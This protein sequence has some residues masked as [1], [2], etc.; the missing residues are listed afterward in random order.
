MVQKILTNTGTPFAVA[1]S[2]D[3]T[4]GSWLPHHLFDGEFG[5]MSPTNTLWLRISGTVHQ[6]S[7]SGS[8]GI[9]RTDLSAV[10]PLSYNS[11][12]GVFTTSMGTG[13]LIGRGTAA[14]GVMEEITIGSGLTLSGTTLT[15]AG[16]GTPAG[17]TTEIQYNNAG[18]FGASD[19]FTWTNA[20]KTLAAVNSNISGTEGL[21]AYV[22]NGGNNFMTFRSAFLENRFDNSGFKITNLTNSKIWFRV[23][24][25]VGSDTFANIVINEVGYVFPNTGGAAGTVLTDAAGD[26]VLS[27]A[28]AFTIPLPVA[29]GGTAKTGIAANKILVALT[30][31]TYTEASY[32]DVAE[33]T[34]A[35][36]PTFSAGL[37]PSGATTNTYRWSRVGNATTVRMTLIYAVA[38]TTIT[39]CLIP[40]PADLPDPVFPTG[41]TGAGG[42]V[43]YG[44][45][46]MSGTLTGSVA[47]QAKVYIRRNAANDGWEFGIESAT[48]TARVFHCFITYYTS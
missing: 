7:V 44:I 24:E 12:T 23:Q 20:T 16:G 9:A 40:K 27:W 3:H 18:A 15:A 17:A 5:I 14:T 42:I 41:V 29:S 33:Q 30:T 34:V 13:K 10:A 32:F 45:G 28:A 26:G 1:P 38:G 22:E 25:N 35:T 19:H 36:T 46:G 37:V 6:I 8:T 4:D 43:S 48:N 31:D 11:G 39:Q 21:T 2:A 47:N